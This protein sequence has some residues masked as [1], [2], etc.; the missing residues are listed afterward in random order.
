MDLFLVSLP[1]FIVQFVK[2]S[3]GLKGG[4]EPPA[5][6]HAERQ[7][8]EKARAQEKVLEINAVCY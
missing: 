8:M 2:L 5:F 6:Q 3:G 1:C 7:R 4:A